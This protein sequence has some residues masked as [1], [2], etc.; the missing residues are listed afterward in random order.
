MRYSQLTLAGVSAAALF[1]GCEDSTSS[2]QS[3]QLGVTEP[4][5]TMAVGFTTTVLARGNAGGFHVNSK[6][7]DYNVEIN[8]PDNTDFVMARNVVDPGGSSG[9]HSHPGPVLVV[10]K[11]GTITFYRAREHGNGNDGICSSTSYPAGSAFIEM[12]GQL[13]NAR[14]EGAVTDTV[15][16]TFFVPAGAATRIDQPAPGGNCPN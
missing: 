13:A 7:G 3:K 10:V 8:A 1:L 11:T 9:W 14:N 5:M 16:A 4:A 12:G 15:Y 6:V 2:R